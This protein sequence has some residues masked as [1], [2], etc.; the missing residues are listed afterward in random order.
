MNLVRRWSVAIRMPRGSPHPLP[1]EDGYRKK[2]FGFVAQ[3]QQS[4]VLL[5]RLIVGSG[6]DQIERLEWG[7]EALRLINLLV[8]FDRRQLG[9]R[10]HGF[11]L[12]WMPTG[13]IAPSLP[14]MS[15]RN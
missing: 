5:Q 7:C 9:D 12:Y 4:D 6:G 8:E 2:T 3:I 15:T 13:Q 10:P 11:L 1:P 14:T